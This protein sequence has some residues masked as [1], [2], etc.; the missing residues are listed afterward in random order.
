M[1]NDINLL[2]SKRRG[3]LGA[4]TRKI[5]IIRFIA[6]SLL[7]V[8]GVMSVSVFLLVLASPLPRLKQEENTLLESLSRQHEKITKQTLIVNRL[9]E[10]SQIV[11]KRPKFRDF[12]LIFTKD[13]PKEL[14]IASLE[15]EQ[16]TLKITL[17]TKSLPSLDTYIETLKRIGKED[18]RVARIIM[19]SFGSSKNLYQAEFVIEFL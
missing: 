12:M 2:Y 8:A 6:I 5:K 7:L 4:L 9:D 1:T 15:V 19:N 16:K 17:E 18:K 14:E 10:I 3:A 11:T 13:I